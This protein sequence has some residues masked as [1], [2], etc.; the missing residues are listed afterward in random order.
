MKRE[1]KF[2]DDRTGYMREKKEFG[3][4]IAIWS[5]HYKNS[6]KMKG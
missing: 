4:S 3:K 2:V 1:S 6:R 5:K